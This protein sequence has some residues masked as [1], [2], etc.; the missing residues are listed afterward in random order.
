MPPIWFR[1][2]EPFS[3]NYDLKKMLASKSI[4][5]KKEIKNLKRLF[6]EKFKMKYLWEVTEYFSIN[7]NYYYKNYDMNLI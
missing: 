4:K 5:S 3:I 2:T 7:I 1:Y 6:S